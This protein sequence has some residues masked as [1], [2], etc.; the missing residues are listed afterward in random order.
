MIEER[1]GLAVERIREMKKEQTAKEPF[2]DY[3]QDRKSTRLN[4]NH[5]IISS[6]PSSS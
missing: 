4:S 2:T 1:Y 6:I 5:G 3:F